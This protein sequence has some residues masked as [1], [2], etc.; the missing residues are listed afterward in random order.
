[1]WPL[2][3]RLTGGS[4]MPTIKGHKHNTPTARKLAD[5]YE[6]MT[7][8]AFPLGRHNAKIK[9][10]DGGMGTWVWELAVISGS[11]MPLD[12]GSVVPASKCAAN[13]KHIEFDQ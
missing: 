12:F 3:K 1:M 2:T 6:R 13:P 9:V 8:Q 5:H 7:G 4:E 11:E 10:L